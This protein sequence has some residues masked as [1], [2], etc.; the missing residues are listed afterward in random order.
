[1][2]VENVEKIEKIDLIEKIR[3]N[4]KKSD[5]I[6]L[7]EKILIFSNPG[8]HGYCSAAQCSETRLP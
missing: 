4:L 1:M 2:I 7:F 6:D 3:F 5:L 8:S